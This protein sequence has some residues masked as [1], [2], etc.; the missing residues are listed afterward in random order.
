M[1]VIVGAEH[2]CGVVV[3]QVGL[4]GEGQL[5]HIS[6]GLD[7]GRLHAG[8]IE[9]SPVEGGMVIDISHYG[10]EPILLEGV[11]V[12]KRHA[13]NMRIPVTGH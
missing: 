7:I 6:E 11:Q 13:L 10:L 4:S 12:L 1:D 8:L 9:L 3:P 5:D 2:A